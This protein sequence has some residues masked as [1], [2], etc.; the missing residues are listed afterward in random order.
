[1]QFPALT[2][3]YL[4]ETITAESPWHH[5]EQQTLLLMEG[6]QSHDS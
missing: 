4:F 3:S 6:G 5:I 2:E 1:M